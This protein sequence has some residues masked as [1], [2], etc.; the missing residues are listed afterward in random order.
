MW[1][2]KKKHY[3]FKGQ[4]KET[5]RT[6]TIGGVGGV[7]TCYQL[8]K[9][10]QVFFFLFFLKFLPFSLPFIRAFLF[11]RLKVRKNVRRQGDKT[12]KQNAIVL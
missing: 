3:L 4:E 11:L 7:F 9:V 1:Q 2:K 8:E 12:S 5:T 6:Y 10:E